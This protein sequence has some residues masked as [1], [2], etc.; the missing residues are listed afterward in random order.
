LRRNP[1]AA[2]RLCEEKQ[3]GATIIEGF[4]T[5]RGLRPTVFCVAG[6][7]L[8]SKVRLRNF[9]RLRDDS[10]IASRLDL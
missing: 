8:K 10:P 7:V 2:F 3:V 9:M 6:L 5:S 1:A 4:A